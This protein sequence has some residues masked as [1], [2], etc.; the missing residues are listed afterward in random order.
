MILGDEV[1]NDDDWTFEIGQECPYCHGEGIDRSDK[2]RLNP[3][4]CGYCG[5]S[6]RETRRVT[7]AELLRFIEGASGGSDG[8]AL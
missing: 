6:G 1:L 4:T 8:D 3:P 7:L 5:G 2:L